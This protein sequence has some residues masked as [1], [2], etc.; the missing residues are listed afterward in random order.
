[1]IRSITLLRHEVR[2]TGRYEEGS[3]FALLGFKIGAIIAT[4]HSGVGG[5]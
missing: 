1:M 2:A 5:A 4:F 3:S